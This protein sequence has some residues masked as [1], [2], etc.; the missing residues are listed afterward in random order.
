MKPRDWIP[1]R[2]PCT[3]KGAE[4]SPAALQAAG[5][6][7]SPKPPGFTRGWVPAAFQAAEDRLSSREQSIR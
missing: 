2:P 3:L 5:I 7:V 6:G 1:N 4:G